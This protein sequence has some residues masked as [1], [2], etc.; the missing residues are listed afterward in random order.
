MVRIMN[1]AADL[2]QTRGKNFLSKIFRCRDEPMK[3]VETRL[4][5]KHKKTTPLRKHG[6]KEKDTKTTLHLL[7]IHAT[8]A[9]YSLCVFFFSAVF[10]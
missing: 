5:Q 4:R 10:L 9:G 8:D 7:L 2:I 1:S 6:G 3:R